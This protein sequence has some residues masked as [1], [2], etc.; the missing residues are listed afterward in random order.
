MRNEIDVWAAFQR[1]E[2]LKIEDVVKAIYGI[3]VSEY[4]KTDTTKELKRYR[5]RSVG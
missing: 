4:I 3:D 2:H 5:K 1:G